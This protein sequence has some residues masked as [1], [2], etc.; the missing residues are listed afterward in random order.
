MSALKAVPASVDRPDNRRSRRRVRDALLWAVASFFAGQFLLTLVMERGRADLRDPEYAIRLQRLRMCQAEQPD[1]PLVLMLG[2]SH[3]MNGFR[4]DCLNRLASSAR[5]P[6]LSFNYGLLCAGPLREHYCLNHLLADQVRPDLLLIEIMPSLYNAP[7][8]GR[9][10]D[11]NWL[12]IPPLTLTDLIELRPFVDRP[13]RL[14]LPWLRSRL[15]PWNEH[16]QKVLHLLAGSWGPLP[17]YVKLQ[18][19]ADRWGWQPPPTVT[20]TP[21]EQRHHLEAALR[22]YGPAYPDFRLGEQSCRAICDL[23]ETCRR[24]QIPVV[25]VRMPESSVFRGCYSSQMESAIPALGKSLSERYGAPFIDAQR[26]IPDSEFW[27]GHHL[28]PEGA[29]H[30]TD[31]LG[32]EVILPWLE[33]HSPSPANSC[34]ARGDPR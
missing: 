2:S 5:K 4:P 33:R 17:T 13:H 22:Q 11:E 31:R 9:F 8:K 18:E 1:R 28:L 6:I 10:C 20:V 34:I 21:E 14:Y 19:Q 7:G 12:Y 15:E 32:R 24:E 29:Q 23:L 16:R 30:F 3:V 26:W 27:D 25:L